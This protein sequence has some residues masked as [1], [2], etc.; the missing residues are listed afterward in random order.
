MRFSH[1]SVYWLL[2]LVLLIMWLVRASACEGRHS[3]FLCL[4]LQARA[5]KKSVNRAFDSLVSGLPKPL[6]RR[7]SGG[8]VSP[9]GAKKELIPFHS[10]VSGLPK[11][12]PR[13]QSG[14]KVSP[15]GAK[16]ELIPFHSLVSGLPKP[17]PSSSLPTS[18]RALTLVVMPLLSVSQAQRMVIF[19]GSFFKNRKPYAFRKNKKKK[20]LM[21]DWLPV[22]KA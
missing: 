7:Q 11:P 12:L 22:R 9:S 19:H 1:E 5:Q 2:V 13:R 8:K 18:F 10:L 4:A 3:F 17:L 14:G 21:S 6:P 15:S 16:K 20:E